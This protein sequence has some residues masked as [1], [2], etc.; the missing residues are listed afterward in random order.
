ME[1][2]NISEGKIENA[3]KFNYGNR[4]RPTGKLVKVNDHEIALMKYKGKV[5]AMD[6]K[7]PHLGT[8]YLLLSL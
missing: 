1:N 2:N 4:N 5:Y 8:V 3:G 6:E 7:C